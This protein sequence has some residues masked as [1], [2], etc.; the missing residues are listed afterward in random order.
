MYEYS[1]WINKIMVE[2]RGRLGRCWKG[3]RPTLKIDFYL[4]VI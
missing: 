1:P 3:T 4:I 2:V